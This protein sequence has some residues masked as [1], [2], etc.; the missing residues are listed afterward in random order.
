MAPQRSCSIVIQKTNMAKL[1]D[2]SPMPFGEHKGKMMVN[3]PASYLLFLLKADKCTPEVKEYII[4]NK[5]VLDYE[6]TKNI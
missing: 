4:E 2:K 1:T 5:E 6:V 3:V